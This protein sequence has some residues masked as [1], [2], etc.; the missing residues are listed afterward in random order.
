MRGGFE[1]KGCNATPVGNASD[2]AT[3]RQPYRTRTAIRPESGVKP[4]EGHYERWEAEVA[5]PVGFEAAAA[6]KGKGQVQAVGA[7]VR[8]AKRSPEACGGWRSDA[9]FAQGCPASAGT[10]EGAESE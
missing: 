3:P 4:Y 8:G 6:R 2:D 7:A 10:S 1:R 9:D 5:F